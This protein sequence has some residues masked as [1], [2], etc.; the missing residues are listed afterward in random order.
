MPRR[1]VVPRGPKQRW[2]K[3]D[4]NE[5]LGERQRPSIHPSASL[6]V[7]PEVQVPSSD[8]IYPDSAASVMT[9]APTAPPTEA[10]QHAGLVMGDQE[11]DEPRIAATR[12]T[13]L[14]AEQD[15]VAEATDEIKHESSMPDEVPNQPRRTLPITSYVRALLICV[16]AL[17]L[18][19]WYQHYRYGTRIL[20][21]TLSAISTAISDIRDIQRLAEDS[22]RVQSSFMPDLDTLCDNLWSAHS[23][24]GSLDMHVENDLI[25]RVII[26]WRTGRCDKV[27]AAQ[28]SITITVGWIRDTRAPLDAAEDIYNNHIP[29]TLQH[30]S[31]LE[32]RITILDR[33]NPYST[34][35]EAKMIYYKRSLAVGP[36]MI[37]EK[38]L[39]MEE[40]E[41]EH[42]SIKERISKL[43]D[44]R[45]MVEAEEKRMGR[46]TEYMEAV[47]T[48][49]ARSCA[50]TESE[51]PRF[52]QSAN[53]TALHAAPRTLFH[54]LRNVSGSDPAV[55]ARHRKLGGRNLNF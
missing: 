52:K 8:T 14:P 27:R 37:E 24:A 3:Q 30:L 29:S 35:N 7:A 40:L 34:W 45:G 19:F 16:V 38:R 41:S 49:F 1:K 18:Y 39:K 50:S 6:A 11:E 51:Q 55:A 25:P 43:E 13:D 53:D 36:E 5:D 4:N 26:A 31:E 17:I 54:A 2:D 12:R 33:K 32:S 22:P 46:L 44:G 47:D 10:T 48:E 28:N 42:E 20:Q 9:G 15:T 23:G 21:P